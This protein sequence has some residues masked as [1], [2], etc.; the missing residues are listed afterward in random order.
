MPVPVVVSH[1]AHPAKARPGTSA[2]LPHIINL[3]RESRRA[4]VLRAPGL[5]PVRLAVVTR[6]LSMPPQVTRRLPLAS[7]PANAT[8][9]GM[10]VN[11]Y[12][13]ASTNRWSECESKPTHAH[14]CAKMIHLQQHAQTSRPPQSVQ[15]RG[16]HESIIEKGFSNMARLTT[17][18]TGSP[19]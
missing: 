13:T 8:H 15:L 12:N 5:H 14:S 16:T 11:E 9:V 7:H 4:I 17:I 3:V 6:T 19:L 2:A 18:T 10:S 1:L